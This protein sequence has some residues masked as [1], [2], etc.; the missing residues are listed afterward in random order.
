MNKREADERK[1]TVFI[2]Y[3]Q[4]CLP[5]FSGIAYEIKCY[6]ETDERRKEIAGKNRTRVHWEEKVEKAQNDTG[7]EKEKPH[8]LFDY[9]IV[10]EL[11][12]EAKLEPV[13]VQKKNQYREHIICKCEKIYL[14]QRIFPM[15]SISSSLV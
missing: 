11:E 8:F 13:L 5:V 14:H 15:I 2:A 4:I 10:L 12:H 6:E 9:Q 7:D 1:S 3:P